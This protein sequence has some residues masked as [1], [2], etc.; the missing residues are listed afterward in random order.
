MAGLPRVAMTLPQAVHR[1][2]AALSQ[3]S[4]FAC[5]CECEMGTGNWS[6]VELSGNVKTKD[7]GNELDAV[8]WQSSNGMQLN[9]RV[10]CIKCIQAKKVLNYGLPE[11]QRER[12]KER[13]WKR[14][15]SRDRDR[16]ET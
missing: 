12:K 2:T 10:M 8:K 1:E 4:E 14:E 15:R 7:S 3:A 13:E 6:P 16:S 9:L 11:R 5:E